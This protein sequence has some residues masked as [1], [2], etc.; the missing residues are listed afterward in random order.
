MRTRIDLLMV[1]LAMLVPLTSMAGGQPT[2]SM[3]DANSELALRL[4]AERESTRGCP[5]ALWARLSHARSVLGP[6]A[7]TAKPRDVLLAMAA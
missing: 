7:G 2:G 3:A 6:G 5:V 4:F 1:V